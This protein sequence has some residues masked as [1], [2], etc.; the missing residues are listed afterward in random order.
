MKKS[1]FFATALL[2]LAS[3]TS[4]EFTGDKALGE[5]NGKA[6]ISFS[7]GVNGTTRAD[8]TGAEAA[9]DLNGKFYVYGI[10]TESTDGAGNV[11]AGNLVYNNYVVEWADNS[12]YTT[13]SNTMG[14]EYVGKSLSSDE[15]A[16]ITANSGTAVQT[17]KYWDWGAP[18][19]TFYAFT[20]LPADITGNKVSVVKNQTVTSSVYDNGYT[21]TLAAG[22]NLDKLYFAE[23][24]NITKANN[25]D[26]TQANKY[27]GNV[28]F[29]FHNSATKVRVA[30]YETIPGYTVTIN[31]F[32]VDNDGT[33]PAFADMTD[34]VTD[35]F[36][37]NL[38]N[39][40]SGVAGT[41]TVTYVSSGTNV[42][43]PKVAFA[44]TDGK[45]KV[46]ALGTNLKA[47]TVLG[48]NITNAVYDK[49]DKSY[50]SVFP[51]ED[52]DQNL[53]LKISY[54]LTCAATGEKIV[55]TDATA[56]IPAKY[57]CWKPGF[58]YT[59]IFKVSDN[60]NGSTGTPGTNPT[61]LY[62]I[63][64]DAT[65][66]ITE[67]GVAEFITT[68]SEASITTFG[69]K[70]GKYVHDGSEYATGSD[71]YATI[72][73]N[74]AVV[75]PTLGTNVNLYKNVQSSDAT[76]FPVTEASLAEAIAET[77]GSAGEKITYTLDNAIGAKVTTVPGEDGVDVTINA[78]KMAGLTAGTYAVEYINGAKKVYKIIVVQ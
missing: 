47:T 41:M 28:T 10:K 4:D 34:N 61:G 31:K 63:T 74:S 66:V 13:T 46:L 42:N 39:T 37:A 51:Q 3:C 2:A 26:R 24:V 69:V 50:T 45:S 77:G 78:I 25:T 58:A 56:E 9:A 30:M 70:S 36:A 49:S 14:W 11:Q 73:E 7:S 57:L 8:K 53:K 65:E 22:A 1:L 71:I 23:R 12:A 55:V 60:T 48:E 19:Y 16:K 17:I 21:V 40:A 62:P 68:V 33:N 67:D 15:A 59:Y 72:V 5:A 27:G 35:N 54:T 43:Y 75:E 20:A 32:S 76:N 29:R 64:F 52:N 6:F 18:D 44:P 38:Q